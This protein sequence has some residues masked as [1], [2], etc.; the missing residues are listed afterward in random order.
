MKASTQ[1][2]FRLPE[3]KK[4]QYAQLARQSHESISE[5]YRLG[6][7]EHAKHQE[8]IIATHK[9]D[10]FLQNDQAPSVKNEDEIEKWLSKN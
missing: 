7:E 2:H 5:F 3:S 9:L 6:A 8:A 10:R 1:I 4:K